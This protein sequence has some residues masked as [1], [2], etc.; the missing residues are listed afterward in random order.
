MIKAELSKARRQGRPPVEHPWWNF[1]ATTCLRSI[2]RAAE[3]DII[4]LLAPSMN[5]NSAKDDVDKEPHEQRSC[6]RS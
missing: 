3:R 6:G 4:S 5:A 2:Q 1:L